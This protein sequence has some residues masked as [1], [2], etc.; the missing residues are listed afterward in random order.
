[1]KVFEIRDESERTGKEDFL[2]GF[3]FYYER[4]KRFQVELLGA[5]DEWTSPFVF[6]KAVSEGTLSFGPPLSESFVR[7]RIIPP[8]RQN[9][10]SIL[11]ANGLP[12][13][14]EYRLLALSEGRCAQDDLHLV[15]TKPDS[16]PDEILDRLDE[17]VKEFIPLENNRLLVFFRDQKTVKCDMNKILGGRREFARVLSSAEIFGNARLSPGGNGVEWGEELIVPAEK[18]RMHGSEA[19]VDLDAMI[20]FAQ[21]RLADTT[22]IASL[23]SCSRQYI[24]QLVREGRL[25]PIKEGGN[26]TLFLKSEVEA[27]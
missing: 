23:L 7:Q 24:G 21:K 26:N 10:G 20:S 27:M 8:D 11:K 19:D 4:K 3:L 15:R 14:D 5:V 2:V 17:K 6:S 13:Y 16:L 9:L 18:L 25:H 12:E 1:M 22:G